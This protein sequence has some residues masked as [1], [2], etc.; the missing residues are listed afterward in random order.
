MRWLSSWRFALV[1]I[2]VGLPGTVEDIREWVQVLGTNVLVTV[3]LMGLIAHIMEVRC[4]R[5]YPYR[6][7]IDRLRTRRRLVRS[8]GRFVISVTQAQFDAL[9]DEERDDR[10][11]TYHIDRRN[12]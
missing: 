9:S 1:M 2:A 6:K 4:N 12:S 11:F 8:R 7:L 10:R 3:A 5:W